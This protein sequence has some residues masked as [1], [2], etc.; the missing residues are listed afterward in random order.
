MV[1]GCN[2]HAY[3][4]TMRAAL[5]CHA[6]A[7]RFGLPI[8]RCVGASI[9]SRSF[10]DT[11]R[12]LLLQGARARAC[13]GMQRVT[14]QA[15]RNGPSPPCTQQ[16]TRGDIPDHLQCCSAVACSGSSL[17]PP[18]S[19]PHAPPFARKHILC[20]CA[21]LA[22]R[23]QQQALS[24]RYLLAGRRLETRILPAAHLLVLVLSTHGNKGTAA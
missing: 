5:P 19:P 13:G 16:H 24:N 4:V 18:R 2:M 20:T 17:P 10:V 15:M 3:G 14:S 7:G 12:P 8:C 21:A 23:R 1:T 6:I 22:A 11:L 9:A